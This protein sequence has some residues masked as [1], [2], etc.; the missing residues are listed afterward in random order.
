[1]LEAPDL[2]RQPLQR[3]T[4]RHGETALRSREA[5]GAHPHGLQRGHVRE[6]HCRRVP[7]RALLQRE[8]PQGDRSRELEP[9]GRLEGEAADVQLLQRLHALQHQRLRLQ[10]G[11]VAERQVLQL[12]PAGQVQGLGPLEAVRAE[13]HLLQ[14][15]RA[16]QIQCEVGHDSVADAQVRHRVA[17]RQAELA[18]ALREAARA[19]RQTLQ[20]GQTVHAELLRV[21]EAVRTNCDALQ[22]G[23]TAQIESRHVGEG[24]RTNRDALQ[25]GQSGEMKRREGGEGTIAKE[26]LL[27]AGGDEREGAGGVG[28][29]VRPHHHA[30]QGIELGESQVPHVGEAVRADGQ[31]LQRGQPGEVEA[32][33]GAERLVPNGQFRQ[34][35][36]VLDAQLAGFADETALSEEHAPEMGKRGEREVLD[37][38]ETAST[39]LQ[40]LQRGKALQGKGAEEMERSAEHAQRLQCHA[41]LDVQLAILSR[42]TLLLEHDALQTLQ[43]ANPHSEN[44]TQGE[45]TDRKAFEF[46]KRSKIKHSTVDVVTLTI[47][48]HQLLH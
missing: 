5:P 15:Q 4:V 19:D 28:E 7:E 34:G 9:R 44:G 11:A 35:L 24:V 31:S 8:A 33:E 18:A 6:G 26:Q 45:R 22:Y 39:D 3:R 47:G 29:A 36:A 2:R 48:N 27:N 14:E 12:R 10:E 37:L 42:K 25:R 46:T 40:R 41:V 16:A 21:D 20:R 30:P 38:R 1:M 43:I 13:R 17:V 23:Q 32:S